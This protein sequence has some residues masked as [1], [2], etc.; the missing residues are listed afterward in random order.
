MS[1]KISRKALTITEKLSI[2]EKYDANTTFTKKK[3]AKL[4]NI[5]E[6]TLRTI[7]YKRKEIESNAF[8]G[9]TKRKKIKFGKY[10]TLEKI[11]VEWIHEA[12]VYSVPI[13]G[14]IIQEKA[15]EISKLLNIKDFNA[16]NGWLDRFKNRHHIVYSRINGKFKS[17]VDNKLWFLNLMSKYTNKY[18]SKDIFNACEFGLFFKVMP[19]KSIMYKNNKCSNGEL[20]EERLTVLICANSDGTEKLKPL[21]IGKSLQPKCFTNIK[22][23]PCEYIAQKQVWMTS[24]HFSSWVKELDLKMGEK[25]REILLFL[26]SCPVHSKNISLKN[27]KLVF[28]PENVSSKLQPMNQGI[29]KVLKRY[30]RKHLFLR[31]LNVIQNSNIKPLNIL[32]ALYYITAAWNSI[33]PQIIAN[34]FKKAGIS[35]SCGELVDNAKSNDLEDESFKNTQINFEEY[36]EVDENLITYEPNLQNSKKEVNYVHNEN[37][38]EE[39]DDSTIEV[40]PTL[41]CTMNAINVVRRFISTLEKSEAAMYNI[42]CVENEIVRKQSN[43]L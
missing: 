38:G 9:P 27:M 40:L 6:S 1:S 43:L 28:F 20:S 25:N 12:N 31:Y 16:T 39:D 41:S 15:L 2:L 36:V 11:L 10:F 37:N 23:F 3:L 7:I 22:T 35:M 33:Q 19:D 34:S 32:D 18:A 42:N 30:Y 17:D 14:P 26:D 21:V 13:N 5:P 8:N 4:L 29:I 24:E